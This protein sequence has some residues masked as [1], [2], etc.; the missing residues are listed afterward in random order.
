[1][2][3]VEA[4]WTLIAAIAPI[5]WGATY[6]VTRQ[7]LPA[8]QPLW[9]AT[10]R[11][12]PAGMVLLMFARRRPQGVWWWRSLVLGLLTTAAFLPLVY[13]AGALLPSNIAAT[14][15]SSSAVVIMLVAWPLLGQ[16]PK[17]LSAIGAVLGIVGVAV[18]LGG[19]TGV[20][21][22]GIAASIAAMLVSSFGFVLT[23]RW[24]DDTSVL[25]V[26]AWQLTA[27][28]LV[29]LPVAVLVEGAPPELDASALLAFGYVSIVA[30]ALAF[31][32]WYAALR[33]LTAGAVGLV[34]L[35]NPLTGVALGT[36]LAAEAFG[37]REAVGAAVVL[38]GVLLGQVRRHPLP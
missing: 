15:M 6:Y 2:P 8:E 20:D 33:R 37:W 19:G 27:G 29:L 22:V 10:L 21:P 7:F 18:M 35:L 13:L 31:V 4:K 25:A 36:A 1:M 11:A 16:R 12:L 38:G 26:T 3:S 9:G 34:G 5:S 14:V 28:G 32:A 30:T 24:K 23:T 17:L